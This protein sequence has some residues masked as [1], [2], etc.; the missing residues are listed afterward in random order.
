[1]ELQAAPYHSRLPDV[2]GRRP[3][4]DADLSPAPKSGTPKRRHHG[5]AGSGENLKRALRHT[6]IESNV[7]LSHK[8]DLT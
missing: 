8:A 7:G 5:A 6:A 1:M 4:G 2:V 3:T